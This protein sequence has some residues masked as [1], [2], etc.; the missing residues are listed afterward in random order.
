[1][2]GGK[3]TKRKE[4]LFLTVGVHPTQDTKVQTDIGRQQKVINQ[5]S[6]FKEKDELE[7]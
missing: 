5:F 2:K 7:I 1:M 3:K 4:R 6:E